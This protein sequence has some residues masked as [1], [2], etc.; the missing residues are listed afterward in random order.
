MAYFVLPQYCSARPESLLQNLKLGPRAG[1][2]FF[3]LM[4]CQMNDIE[5]RDEVVQSLSVS[6]G[7]LDDTTIYHIIAYPTPPGVDLSQI[8]EDKI[9]DVMQKIVLAPYF[10]AILE[11][12]ETHAVA[13]YILG[14]SPDGFTTFRTVDGT[15]NANLGRGC[16]PRLESF[17]EFLRSKT[18]AR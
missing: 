4:T 6:T 18:N 7:K 5:P 15:M 11:N 10:S 9:L 16:E 17:V 13:Y 14:Q 12:S 2:A 1:A 3:Y 8:P